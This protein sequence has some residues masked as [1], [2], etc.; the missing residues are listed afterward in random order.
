MIKLRLSD[1]ANLRS[2]FYLCMPLIIMGLTPENNGLS[3]FIFIVVSMTV[4]F[5]LNKGIILTNSF[6][7]LF[8]GTYSIIL[9]LSMYQDIDWHGVVTLSYFLGFVIPVALLLSYK[10]NDRDVLFISI[11]FVVVSVL[12]ATYSILFSTRYGLGVSSYHWPAIIASIS[13]LLLLYN[14]SVKKMII[15]IP[16]MMLNIY[17]INLSYAEQA[18]PI[19]FVGLLIIVISKVRI[20]NGALYLFSLAVLLS[21]VYFLFDNSSIGTISYVLRKLSKMENLEFILGDRY[22][23]YSNAIDAIGSNIFFGIGVGQFETRITHIGRYPHNIFLTI[24]LSFGMIGAVIFLYFLYRIVYRFLTEK[25]SKNRQYSDM[26]L[27]I[28]SSFFVSA[29]FSGGIIGYRGQWIMFFLLY[30]YHKNKSNR[31]IIK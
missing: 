13:L 27:L 3:F 17:T 8:T 16:I 29:L 22:E 26:L 7:L 18:I 4:I 30:F 1:F 5:I 12:L 9:F 15:F 6:I 11:G 25:K 20:K 28:F 10:I 24:W 14:F 19:L 31:S 2:L 21:F 23:I